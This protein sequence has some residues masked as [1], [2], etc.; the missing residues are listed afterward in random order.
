[1][2]Q[3]AIF[4]WA[5]FN[6]LAFQPDLAA[7]KVD[8]E[9]FIHLDDVMHRATRALRATDDSFYPAHHFTRAKRLGDIVIG[10]QFKPAHT[11]ILLTFGGEHDHWHITPLTNG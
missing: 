8:L 2:I 4:C 9:A 11:I 5:Q 1:M 7:V 6:Q 10:S 3:E